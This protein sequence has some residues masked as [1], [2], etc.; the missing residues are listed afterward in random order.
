MMSMHSSASLH[1]HQKATVAMANTAASKVLLRFRLF[2]K[3]RRWA[4]VT[5]GL[6]GR[7][8]EI[9]AMDD[10]PWMALFRWVAPF[11]STPLIMCHSCKPR[12]QV[13]KGPPLTEP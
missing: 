13:L 12:S 1:W 10:D 4:S 8:V 5:G 2:L 6:L 7:E 11:H 9:G 3:A